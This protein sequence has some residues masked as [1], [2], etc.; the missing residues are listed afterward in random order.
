M[1]EWDGAD[2]LSS[3][4]RM[5]ICVGM[6]WGEKGVVGRDRRRDS[7]RRLTG[8]CSPRD[9]SCISWSSPSRRMMS[10]GGSG[11]SEGSGLKLKFDIS[12]YYIGEEGWESSESSN[13]GEYNR[14]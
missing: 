8:H 9:S 6:G 12:N 13:S 10:R 14:R 5:L 7:S 4:S 3:Y 2:C 1:G 11:W